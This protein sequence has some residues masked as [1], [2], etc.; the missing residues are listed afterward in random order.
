MARSGSY[1]KSHSLEQLIL[2][3]GVREDERQAWRTACQR[4]DDFYL[5]FRYPDATPA[6]S[7]NEPTHEDASAALAAAKKI[8]TEIRRSVGQER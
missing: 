3:G 8:V 2:M 5:P 1:P 7:M 6:G 4:L